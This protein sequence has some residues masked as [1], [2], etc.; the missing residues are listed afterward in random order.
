MNRFLKAQ[1]VS[2]AKLETAIIRWARLTMATGPEGWTTTVPC[3]NRDG[4]PVEAI[5]RI[6]LVPTTEWNE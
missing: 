1:R 4:D 5:V 3:R 2:R 6:D